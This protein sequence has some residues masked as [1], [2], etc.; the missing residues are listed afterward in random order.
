MGHDASDSDE[1]EDTS[2]RGSW[3]SLQTIVTN[4]FVPI[5]SASTIN[6]HSTESAVGQL[7]SEHAESSHSATSANHES[8]INGLSLASIQNHLHRLTRL[9]QKVE[10]SGLDVVATSEES[11]TRFVQLYTVHNRFDRDFLRSLSR[12]WNSLE[13]RFSILDLLDLQIAFERRRLML[14]NAAGWFWL[15]GDCTAE[16]RRYI[17]QLTAHE[18]EAE[19]PHEEET[20]SPC[21]WLYELTKTIFEL[22]TKNLSGNVRPSQ[23]F[24]LW[25]DEDFVVDIPRDPRTSDQSDSDWILTHVVRTIR[26]WLRFPT[27][28]RLL[29][30]FFVGHLLSTFHNPDLLLLPVVWRHHQDIKAR[31]LGN[32]GGRH[33]SLTLRMLEPFINAIHHHP[34]SRYGSAESAALRDISSLVARCCPHL[35]SMTLELVRCLDLNRPDRLHP[36]EI[37]LPLARS[38]GSQSANASNTLDGLI[39]CVRELLPM[40]QDGHVHALPNPTKLQK[41]VAS[42]PDFYCP[43]RELAPSRQ[44]FCSPSGPF[45]S[46]NSDKPGAFASWILCRLALFESAKLQIDTICFFSTIEAWNEFVKSCGY[47]G[48]MQSARQIVNIACYGTPQVQRTQVVSQA[49]PYFAAESK[50]RELLASHAPRRIPFTTC[51]EWLQMTRRDNVREGRSPVRCLPHVGKLV[52]YLLTADLVY[53]GKVAAPSVKEVGRVVAMNSLGSLKG[54]VA[55]GQ[56]QDDKASPEQVVEAFTKVY[57]TLAN[58]FADVKDII[59]FDAIMVEHLLCK[60]QRLLHR[61]V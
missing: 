22:R 58:E 61:R 30:A 24:D 54:L 37:Q 43:F 39:Q 13:T 32:R 26:V 6:Q 21:T 14:T 10:R 44:L 41:L 27:N 3:N 35:R 49:E 33:E 56:L 48:S 42:R 51:F 28:T 55:C 46:D 50:W 34:L 38:R 45:H 40:V 47:D 59:R 29:A 12:M 19:P 11:V 60:Y 15:T 16:A 18:E 23:F 8:F 36:P 4:A 52:A 17:I 31:L 5:Q 9:T 53:A 25:E 20:E 7:E 2:P 57:D 1:D